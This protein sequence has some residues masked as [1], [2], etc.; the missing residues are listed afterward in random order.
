M[1]LAI[2]ATLCA[3]IATPAAAQNYYPGWGYQW[4]G[5]NRWA[6]AREEWWRAHRAEDIARWRAMNGD[7]EG[8]SRAQYWADRHRQIAR[9]NMYGRGGW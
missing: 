8:A 3:L 1:R 6:A 5:P 2:A 9:Q 7:Y 4:N